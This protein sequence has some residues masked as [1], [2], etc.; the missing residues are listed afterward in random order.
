MADR[1]IG[2]TKQASRT[3]LSVRIAVNRY[4]MLLNK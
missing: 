3:R 4:Q 2:W 1:S